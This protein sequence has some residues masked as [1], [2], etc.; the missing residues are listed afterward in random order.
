MSDF[1]IEFL[2]IFYFVILLFGSGSLSVLQLVVLGELCWLLYF[3]QVHILLKSSLWVDLLYLFFIFLA[4]ATIDL[5]SALTLVL[6]VG[7]SPKGLLGAGSGS[8]RKKSNQFSSIT[9]GSLLRRS[10]N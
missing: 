2:C 3:L 8:L 1:Y 7:Y 10:F 9:E 5:S 4:I 6:V